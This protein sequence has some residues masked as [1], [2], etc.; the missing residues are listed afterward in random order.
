MADDLDAYLTFSDGTAGKSAF[1]AIV[2]ETHDVTEKD[3]SSMQ[4]R[5][6]RFGFELEADETEETASK[7]GKTNPHA[8]SLRALQVTKALDVSSPQLL[9]ALTS[10]ARFDS[11]WLWQKKAGGQKG[12]SG[13]YF[14]MIEMRQ[15][16]VTSVEW[17]ANAGD[18]PEETVTLKYQEI[19]AEYLPQK[20]TGELDQ[21]KRQTADYTPDAAWVPDKANK[22]N[23][24][25]K[26]NGSTDIND[27][28]P[29][30]MKPF[31]DKLVRELRRRGV[32]K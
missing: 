4:I 6:Y 23:N 32:V 7:D 17:A 8:P 21:S 13:D 30:Q 26:G 15:V 5:S 19:T 22:G 25:N 29:V 2:G 10:A 24:G 11:V 20:R 27:F 28:D 16:T 18:S 1:P 31:V 14:W 12:A 3:F 9:K